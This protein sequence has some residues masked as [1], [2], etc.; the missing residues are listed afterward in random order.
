MAEHP[1]PG[2]ED[3]L[4]LLRKLGLAP[5]ERPALPA[6]SITVQGNLI[7]KIV[8]PD[9]DEPR[10]MVDFGPAYAAMRVAGEEAAERERRRRGK[11]PS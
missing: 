5:Q 1:I 2:P 4:E 3:R 9:G 7:I 10:G 8:A 6:L 11:P